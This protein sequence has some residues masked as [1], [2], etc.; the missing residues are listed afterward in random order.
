MVQNC[1]IVGARS[2][3]FSRL[4]R[5]ILLFF[6]LIFICARISV[7]LIMSR[8]IPD[9][10]FYIGGT[11]IHHLNY[12]IF[13][14]SGICG[15]LLFRRPEGRGLEVVAALYGIS[16]ALTFDEFG[17]WIHLGGNYWQR[18]SWDAITVLTACFGLVAFATS[19]KRLRPH[20]WLT[21]I[22]LI[23]VIF[24]F[25]FLLVKSF[26]YAGRIVLPKLDKIE[27]T[28]PK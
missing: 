11:H 5:V 17:M 15:Y 22:A 24:I 16:M 27:A 1:D 2:P 14:L 13:L 7:F 10:Y 6:L 3:T 9:L 28:G 12:G 23:F 20:H 21:G 25:F 4:G 18:A 26:K 8:R 19:I